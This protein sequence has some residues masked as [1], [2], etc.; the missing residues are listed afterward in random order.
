MRLIALSLVLAAGGAVTTLDG[1]AGMV[2]IVFGADG[3]RTEVRAMTTDPRGNIYL[4]GATT[5]AVLPGTEYAFQKTRRGRTDGF[6]AKFDVAGNLLWSTFIGGVDAS[7]ARDF[8]DEAR[9]IAVDA[10]GNV[11]VAGRT[12][13]PDFPVINGSQMTKLGGSDGFVAKFDSTGSRLLYSSY[14][15]ALGGGTI[16]E[17]I[18]VGPAGETW[19]G[20][21]TSASQF[22]VTTDL[23]AG[24]GSGAAIV[25]KLSPT[26]APVWTTRLGDRFDYDTGA[27]QMAVDT[28]ARP[29]VVTAGA[30]IQ[31]D[32]SGT[33][34]TFTWSMPGTTPVDIVPSTDGGTIVSGRAGSNVSLQLR[35]AWQSERDPTGNGFVA[36]LGPTGVPHT[37]SY[38]SG[39]AY[40][41]PAYASSSIR[42]PEA[43]RR[44]RI[45]TDAQGTLHLAF[46]VMDL[47]KSPSG[48]SLPVHD[49][50]P[51]FRTV[52]RGDSWT[53]SSRGM[54][55]EVRTLAADPQ[56]GY[57][58]ASTAAGVYRSVDHGESWLLWYANEPG[59]GSPL[60]AVD[61]RD[62][63][64]MYLFGPGRRLEPE[65]C[66]VGFGTRQAYVIRLD[67]DGRRQ[68]RLRSF[69]LDCCQPES[70][71]VSPHD[72]SVW[73]GANFALEASFDRGVTWARRDNGLPPR[74]SGVAPPSTILFD[75]RR[76]DVV[77]SQS[78]YGVARST[79]RGVT[80]E[81]FLIRDQYGGFHLPVGLGLDPLDSNRFFVSASAGGLYVTE[82]R[83]RSWHTPIGV[84][85][86]PRSIA[87]SPVLPFE[88]YTGYS[89]RSDQPPYRATWTVAYSRD[90]GVTW[91]A[92][93]RPPAVGE[94]VF[95]DPLDGDRAFFISNAKPVP[96]AMRMAR[97]REQ[98]GYQEAY[99]STLPSEGV[100]GALTATADGQTI[101]ALNGWNLVGNSPTGLIEQSKITLALI[102]R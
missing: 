68:T 88:I 44:W 30:V 77:F 98:V 95:A 66:V 36:M 20:L 18:A 71:A 69:T 54:L 38:V 75:T 79:D 73:L 96:L 24:A 3:G 9:A 92:A 46:S 29:V 4:T 60:I 28:F 47:V 89:H 63:T 1:R 76:P 58:Y 21:K 70:L 53:P 64:T 6:V 25:M 94:H 2:T 13:A 81:R 99:L 42:D 67:Q 26:G 43:R 48:A 8:S 82:D 12:D 72:G 56:R 10:H 45:A 50:G 97:R 41:R 33:S 52:D 102:S 61:P 93:R 85:G 37:I 101:V 59:E 11:Y 5:A 87:V 65:C 7:A 15:G 55:A 14:I 57:L 91:A 49:N 22:R 39:E 32:T 86:Q 19:I 83:G 74:G 62:P 35:N 90:R 40:F 31:L 80:W 23:S 51:V 34:K 84:I 16:G 27:V 78:I 100:V 17:S